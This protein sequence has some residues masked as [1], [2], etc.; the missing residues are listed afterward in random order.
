MIGMT[1][2]PT[3]RPAASIVLLPAGSLKILLTTSGATKLSTK[4]PTITEGMPARI[5]T[6]GLT[7]LRTRR[8]AYSER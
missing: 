4:K 5:S 3:P 6:I 2:I 8:G 1:R 7:T